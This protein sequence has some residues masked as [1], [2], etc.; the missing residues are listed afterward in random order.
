LQ[1]YCC[2]FR[3]AL[4]LQADRGLSILGVSL[5]TSIMNQIKPWKPVWANDKDHIKALENAFMDDDSP[6]TDHA[7]TIQAPGDRC[8]CLELPAELL[9]LVA[10]FCSFKGL[11]SLR[12]TCRTFYEA[13][14]KRFEELYVD[15]TSYLMFHRDALD[16]LARLAAH[17]KWG[18]KMRHVRLSSVFFQIPEQIDD[19]DD[20]HH[21][22]DPQQMSHATKDMY[23]TN[24]K[25]CWKDCKNLLSQ[26]FKTFRDRN[27]KVS[28]T[29][30]DFPCENSKGLSPLSLHNS[31][32]ELLNCEEHSTSNGFRLAGICMST[33]GWHPSDLRI[34]A[35]AGGFVLMSALRLHTFMAF[36]TSFTVTLE[37][38]C[39]Y[40]T[41][42]A[43]P[44]GSLP[45][46]SDMY[47]ED[48]ALQ[49]QSA[50]NLETLCLNFSTDSWHTILPWAFHGRPSRL[51]RILSTVRLEKLSK[52]ILGNT[53]IEPH[54]LKEFVCRHDLKRLE[55][56]NVGIHDSST[57][58]PT[59]GAHSNEMMWST[60]DEIQEHLASRDGPRA[61]LGRLEI[62]FV[63]SW[64]EDD[65]YCTPVARG[66]HTE[67]ALE[68]GLESDSES[69]ESSLDG[70]SDTS[71]EN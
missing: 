66:R 31:S 53:S 9:V 71:S 54:I 55:L 64:E 17:Q 51:G 56:V 59:I 63:E 22:I 33:V 45:S 30:E 61:S 68:E 15:T 16:R 12:A 52:L 37:V 39:D 11:L 3:L 8:I 43:Q 48:F 69:Y 27:Q 65:H 10:E 46:Q 41:M 5:G 4:T 42:D 58:I 24:R 23:R 47:H 44:F 2:K 40:R 60:I 38:D 26:T 13:T 28:V 18:P 49:L 25:E 36:L 50:Q 14:D 70:I 6:P 34:L 7:V 32:A 35:R 19:I 29:I 67:Q 21:R 62:A 20:F 57:A 1:T